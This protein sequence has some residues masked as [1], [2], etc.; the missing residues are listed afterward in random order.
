VLLTAFLVQMKL[1]AGALLAQILDLH[2]QRRIDP[3]ERAGERGDQRSVAKLA[4]S[5]GRDRFN[6]LALLAAV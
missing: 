5:V 2:L 1:P 3:R 6:Q 4:H